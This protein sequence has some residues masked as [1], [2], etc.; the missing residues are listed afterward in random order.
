MYRSPAG[1]LQDEGAQEENQ[2]TQLEPSETIQLQWNT[3]VT[4]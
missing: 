4:E 2:G 3:A 1:F